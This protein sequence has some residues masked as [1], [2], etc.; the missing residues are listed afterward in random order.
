MLQPFIDRLEP[1]QV[2]KFYME[3]LGLH[4]VS[5]APS[6]YVAKLK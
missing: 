4:N 1:D 6:L 2:T 3:Q 5:V